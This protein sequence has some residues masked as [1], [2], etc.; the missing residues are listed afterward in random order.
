MFLGFCIGAIPFL[1]LI[2]HEFPASFNTPRTNLW[3]AACASPQI[4]G[5]SPLELTDIV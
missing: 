3:F 5:L 2:V 4:I 1:P